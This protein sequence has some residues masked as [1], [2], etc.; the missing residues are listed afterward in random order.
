M[1]INFHRTS[2]TLK[3]YY[4]SEKNLV[5]YLIFVDN[6]LLK[7]QRVISLFRRNQRGN[8]IVELKIA[9]I[10]RVLIIIIEN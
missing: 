2:T 6:I 10:L 7:E 8:L 4:R 1:Q 5:F 9:I 3:R